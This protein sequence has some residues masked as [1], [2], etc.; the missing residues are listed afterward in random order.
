MSQLNTATGSF[1]KAVRRLIANHS[2]L[3]LAIHNKKNE[4]SLANELSSRTALGLIVLWENFVNDLVLAYAED[5]PSR[6]LK[7]M[8][9]RI[10]QSVESKY[11][12]A[13]VRHVKCNFPQS[14]S[15]RKIAALVDEKGMNITARTA[16]DLAARANEILS[17]RYARKFTFDPKDSQFYD[18]VISLRNYLGHFSSRSLHSLRDTISKMQHPDN[19]VFQSS[20]TQIGAYLKVDTSA[21][22]SRTILIG[23]RLEDLAIRM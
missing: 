16:A 7:S 17:G 13:C 21:G 12:A 23:E 5:D 15:A 6:V 8:K 3:L 1:L 9:N 2:E 19:I 22:K 11:G 14:M 20:F 4:A 18:Y 10:L